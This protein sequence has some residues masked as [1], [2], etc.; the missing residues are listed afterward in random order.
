MFFSFSLEFE[1]TF[2]FFLVLIWYCLSNRNEMSMHSNLINVKCFALK[3]QVFMLCAL[4]LNKF[5][6]TSKQC[7]E[8]W[9]LTDCETFLFS[10]TFNFLH[11]FCYSHINFYENKMWFMFTFKMHQN[12]H[13]SVFPKE[14]VSIYD[15]KESSA[16]T[17]TIDKIARYNCW[18]MK[19]QRS[20][21]KKDNIVG[22]GI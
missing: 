18:K 7:V 12:S 17:V 6:Q 11:F 15:A 22:L 2:V 16:E 19:N 3:A 20:K 9:K 13:E 21:S 10:I 8:F 1:L 14:N 5:L 4:N